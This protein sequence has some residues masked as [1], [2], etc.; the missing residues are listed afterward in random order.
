MSR[1]IKF[2]AATAFL[3]VSGAEAQDVPAPFTQSQVVAGHKDYF[4]YC[5]ECH[6]DNLAGSGE[7]PP[8]TGESFSANWSQ[9][10]IHDFYAFVS[11]AM[12]QGLAGDLSAEKYSGIIAYILA[13]N[14]AKPGPAPFNKDSM[15][16]I[17]DVANGQ[18][19]PAVIAPE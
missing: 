15:T 6:G 9:K 17:G 10:N 16:K 12:P 11:T 8:L 4:T 18:I 19:V 5:G 14:G 3:S 7:V 1:Q 2:L 13:A